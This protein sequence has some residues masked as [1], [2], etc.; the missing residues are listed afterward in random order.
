[1][2]LNSGLSRALKRSLPSAVGCFFSNRTKALRTVTPT[3]I[4][5]AFIA[6]IWEVLLSSENR[7]LGPSY[8]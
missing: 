6:Y 2:L 1:M 3:K 5:N 8:F 7:K 4:S